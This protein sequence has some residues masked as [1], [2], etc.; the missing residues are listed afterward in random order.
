MWNKCKITSSQW[1]RFWPENSPKNIFLPVKGK[2]MKAKFYQL[3]KKLINLQVRKINLNSKKKKRR[4][5]LIRKK[6]KERAQ[7]NKMKTL[8]TRKSLRGAGKNWKSPSQIPNLTLS[9]ATSVKKN[10]GQ[11]KLSSNISKRFMKK[12]WSN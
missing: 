6:M 11:K 2:R 1:K 8:L 12:K 5:K 7:A 4:R 10:T 3:K 9:C